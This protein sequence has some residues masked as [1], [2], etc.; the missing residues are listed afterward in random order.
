MSNKPIEPPSLATVQATLAF[1]PATER[2]LW[3]KIGMS[4][5][6]EFA[7]AGFALFDAWSQ[8]APNYDS[9]AVAASWRSF[10]QSGKVSIGSL[11]FEAQQR[12]FDV[13]R[14]STG[15][16]IPATELAK[17][18]HERQT[19]LAQEQAEL[20]RKQAEAASKAG[21]LWHKAATDSQHCAYLQRKNI[22]PYGVRFTNTAS[23]DIVLV[24]MRDA[25]GKLW[26]VQRIF[27]N[28]DKRFLKD[29]RT[30]GCFHVLGDLAQSAWVL[31][32]EGYATAAS[33]HEATGFAVVVAFSAG[34]LKHVAAML[35]TACAKT[36]VLFCADD[37]Q[38]SEQ[39]SG[40]NTGVIAAQNAAASIS[41][42]W[43]KPE[44]LPAQGKD[45]NDLA[46]HHGLHYVKRQIIAIT[47]KHEAS[48]ASDQNS[49]TPGSAKLISL[50]GAAARPAT[51]TE[52]TSKPGKP[53]KAAKPGNTVPTQPG[54]STKPFFTVNDEGVFYHAFHEGEP[55]P[56][57]KI[58]SPLYVIAKTRDTS[59]NEWGYLL[60]FNDPDRCIKR[61]A[62]PAKMLAGDGNQYRADLLAQGLLIEPG[63][64]VKNLL[65]TYIQ[66]A[67]ISERV[68]CV[69]RIGWHD[70]VYVL[71][72]RTLGQGDEQVLFQ[73]NGSVAS[74]FK[75]RGT[76]EQWQTQVAQY[77]RGNSRLLFFVSAGFAAVLLYQAK[78][79]SFGLH[80]IG[81]SSTGKSTVMKLAASIFGGADYA[82]SWHVTDNSLE[83]TAQKHSDALLVLDE[84]G[85]ADPKMVGNITY[86]LSNEKGK[87]RATQH[88]TA[89]KIAAWRTLFISDGELSLEAKMAE[90]GK[91]TKGGQ[92]VRMAHINADAGAGL[93]VFE[94]LHGFSDGAALSRHLV[95]Q[96]QEVHGVAGI[97]FIEWLVERFEMISTSIR[98][99]LQF[100]AAELCPHDA[101]GQVKRVAEF[102]SLVAFGGELATAA[103]ITG[104]E[105]NDATK[106][107]QTCFADWLK[108]RGTAGD[109]EQQRMLGLLPSFLV[110]HG[111][112]RFTWVHRAL[113]DHAPKTLNRA[114]FKRLISKDGNAINNDNDYHKEYGDTMHPDE[115]ETA[116][117]EY[118]LYPKVF[119][120]EV[121]KGFDPKQVAA[122]LADLGV[123]EKD[124]DGK[125]SVL[126]SF[127][128]TK[129]RYYK[130]RGDKLHQLS[131]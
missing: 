12:G 125:S 46:Q 92:D 47:A 60:Q 65:T 66:T 31:V 72:D 59:S 118:Y 128:G 41:G 5:K 109:V 96:V 14:H 113:D 22:Q 35:Q 33:L 1:I 26:N 48:Q 64:K 81:S 10:K 89:K 56:A 123:I 110:Q 75:Q 36:P 13:K 63:V 130:I 11:L 120:E 32:A 52:A 86:M 38:Q 82:Q 54:N 62:M 20:E 50:P 100:I 74:Q 43:C 8:S 34:N 124:S 19:R 102:F 39:R 85:Q 6:S 51:E 49:D 115:R 61:W 104:W 103:G 21:Q 30:S 57:Y 126:K 53:S 131:A 91:T 42:L 17:A 2:E 25:S 90:A 55:L 107:A 24:P 108:S 83:A 117:V 40:K 80:L 44:G 78:V 73:T 88:A 93:G 29:G 27:P 67:D 9:K 58:C 3:V 68:R 95:S 79:Q 127:A 76:L 94:N 77:C 98:P 18:N 119:T 23:G 101:H 4:I 70:K 7:D 116:I 84:L 114:G 129:A 37:D 99:A 111:D 97:A 28:G 15:N 122:K 112:A 69:E 71:P 87:G 106:A 105:E 121:C 45:F 16:A